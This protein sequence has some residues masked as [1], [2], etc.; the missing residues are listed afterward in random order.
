MTKNFLII[1]LLFV[2]LYS[3]GGLKDAKRVLSN[4]KI[5]NTDEFLVKKKEPLILP[6]DYDKIP[7]PDS[8]IE[9]LD[10]KI[11]IK[12]ILKAPKNETIKSSE[13]FKSLEKSILEKIK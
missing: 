10:N 2:I 5:N 8:K 7:S 11:D 12:K 3:C 6:P 13:K 4:E 9:N 1:N